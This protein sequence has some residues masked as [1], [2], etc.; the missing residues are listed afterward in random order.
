[1]N[2]ILVIFGLHHYFGHSGGEG[3]G[4]RRLQLVFGTSGRRTDLNMIP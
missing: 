3:H 2:H 1:M 4:L